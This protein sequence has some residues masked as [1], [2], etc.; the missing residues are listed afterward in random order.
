MPRERSTIFRRFLIDRNFFAHESATC[1]GL[2]AVS[3][4]SSTYQDRREFI[5][6]IVCLIQ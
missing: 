5:H 4:R 1:A 2:Q 6:H 3:N